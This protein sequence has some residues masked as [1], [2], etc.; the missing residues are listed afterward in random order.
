MMAMKRRFHLVS[1]AV[2]MVALVAGCTDS[3]GGDEPEL[4]VAGV[5]RDGSPWRLHVRGTEVCFSD[6]DG[7]KSCGIG[8][9]TPSE[10]H[11]VTFVEGTFGQS[12]VFSIGAVLD[13]VG[14]VRVSEGDTVAYPPVARVG[15]QLGYFVYERI[16]SGGPPTRAVPLVVEPVG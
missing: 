16:D 1:I 3:D 12:R 7:R 10:G 4:V 8:V 15:S 14:G 9:G 11:P 2:A 13:G 5:A 6:D